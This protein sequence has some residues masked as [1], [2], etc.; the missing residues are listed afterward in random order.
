[1][2]KRVL[3][4]IATVMMGASLVFPWSASAHDIDVKKA[5]ELAKEYARGIIKEGRGYITF[6]WRCKK[7]YPGH[8]HVVQCTLE[9]KNAKDKA[10]GVYTCKEVIELFMLAHSRTSNRPEYRIAGRHISSRPC[11]SRWLTDGWV[12]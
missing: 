10:A 2:P 3:A 4:L 11:G 12:D 5:T 7:L 1:M 6:A 9:Y 8:N